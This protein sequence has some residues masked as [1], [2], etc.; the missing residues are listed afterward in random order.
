MDHQ[1]AKSAAVGVL[2][3]VEVQTT[4]HCAREIGTLTEVH[5]SD[6]IEIV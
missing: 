1:H 2:L 4:A 3:A 5:V 6:A